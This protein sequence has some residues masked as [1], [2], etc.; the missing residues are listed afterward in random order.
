M[1]EAASDVANALG[2][3]ADWLNTGPTS[4]VETGFPEG[5]ASRV[6]MR[7][8][9]SLTLDIASRYDQVFLKLYAAAD[10]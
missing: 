8:Y 7:R 2:L 1:A 5:F 9:G 6:E 3:P 10:Q 4:I